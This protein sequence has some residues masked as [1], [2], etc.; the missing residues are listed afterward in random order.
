MNQSKTHYRKVFKSDHLGVADLEDMLEVNT[1][2]IFTVSHVKQEKGVMVAG[3]RGDHN[4]AYFKEKIKPFVLNATNSKTMKSFANGSPFVED[5]NNIPVRL[6][7][8]YNVKMKGDIVGGVRISP[9][10]PKT[11]LA[12]LTPE[13]KNQWS[14]AIVA[15]KRDGNCDAIKKRMTLSPENEQAIMEAAGVTENVA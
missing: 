9:Q 1:P 15:C 14:N 8:D 4:I 5:W 10:Q 11:Q 13:N 7:I 3:R 6:Y 2:L 12:E